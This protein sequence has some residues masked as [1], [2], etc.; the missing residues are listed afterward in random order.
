L[1]YAHGRGVY[2]NLTN[3]CPTACTFCL[4][5]QTRWNYEG[6]NLLLNS[7]EPS[8][9]EVLQAAET[10][11]ATERFSEL[12]FCGYGE[13][14]YRL[15]TMTVVGTEIG[16]RHP[17]IQR[18]LNTI[19]L[20]SLIWGRDIAS[21]LKRCVDAVSVSLNTADPAHWRRL[22]APQ[23]AYAE[24]GFNAVLQFI[25]DCSRAGLDTTV[26]AVRLPGVNVAAVERLAKFLGARFRL[27]PLLRETAQDGG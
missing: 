3:R 12:V 4:K 15:S 25:A 17:E 2:V 11:L 26:T 9:G 23:A 21:E 19:G 22:H 5:R 27:R 20:G 14:T 16:R 8:A 24:K 6:N 10:L 13:S 7:R 18:R 1:V